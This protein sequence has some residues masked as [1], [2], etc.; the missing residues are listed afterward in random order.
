MN[1]ESLLGYSRPVMLG[2]PPH[3]DPEA[4][5]I[6]WLGTANYEVTFRDRVLLLDTFYERGPRMRNLGF[7]LDEIERADAVFIGHPHYDHMSDAAQVAA[8]TGASVVI[9][10]LGADALTRGGLG[11]NKIIE[12]TG[13]GEGDFLEFPEFTVRVLH[14]FHCPVDHPE[15]LMDITTLRNARAK[16]ESDEPP[17]TD[18]EIVLQK[19]LYQQGNQS[20]EV[21]TEGTM[22]LIFE[23]DGYTIV[24]RDSAGP[25]GREEQAHFEANPGCDLAIVALQGFPLQ[26]KQLAATGPLVELYQPKVVIPCHHDDLFPVF[27]DMATEPFKMRIHEQLP[28][29][30]TIQPVYVEPVT[31]DMK[32]GE[33]HIG[34]A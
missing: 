18:E 34:D 1:T 26:R 21:L 31:V 16:W 32:S 23:V 11:G 20:P 13:R 22:C 27:L 7:R 10:P 2:G 25:I 3:P 12:V 5:T 19:E 6:R 30:V 28:A 15:V 9:H 29:T 33:V 24:F 17:L 8:Q 14:G 4:L